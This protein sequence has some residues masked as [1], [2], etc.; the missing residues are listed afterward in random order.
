MSLAALGLDPVALAVIPA[1]FFL[2]GFLKGALGF[3]LPL[4]TMAAIPFVAPVEI[5]LALNAVVALLVNYAQLHEAGR[6]AAVLR[7]FWPVLAGLAPG[8]GVGAMM[9]A[10]VD[11]AALLTMLGLTVLAF[12]AVS[13][14]GARI[15]APPEFEKQ[16]GL[17]TGLAAGVLGALTTSNGPVFLMYLLGLQLDRWTFRAALALMF[18]ATAALAA[19]SYVAIG[20]VDGPR[21]L[22]ALVCVAPTALG[23]GLGRSVGRRLDQRVFRAV[24]TTALGAVGINFILKGLGVT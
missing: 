3:G 7:R 22:M 10:S 18:I 21:A 5:G 4:I 9:L 12:V 23:I 20:V 15:A 11:E 19:A 17:A 13:A 1:A 14:T 2:G 6:G 24:V 16:A 8:V